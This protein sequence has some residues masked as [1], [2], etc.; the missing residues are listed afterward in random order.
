MCKNRPAEL[1]SAGL[2]GFKRCYSFV[3]CF[4]FRPP[5]RSGIIGSINSIELRVRGNAAN[6]KRII[7]A[8]PKYGALFSAIRQQIQAAAAKIRQ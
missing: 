3:S 5:I 4:E 1:Y 2:W 8:F 6:K 7:A